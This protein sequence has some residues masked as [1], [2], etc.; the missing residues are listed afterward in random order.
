M[1]CPQRGGIE[2][3]EVSLHR[4]TMHLKEVLCQWLQILESLPQWWQ[5]NLKDIQSIVEIRSKSSRGDLGFDIAV[6]GSNYPNVDWNRNTTANSLD[7]SILQNPEQFDLVVEWQLR[8]LIQ[9]QRPAIGLLKASE[10]TGVRS[11]KGSLLMAKQLA[12]D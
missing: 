7:T 1:H 3:R 6:G 4:S 2:A 9:K 5:R 10:P 11:G 12:L 8:D